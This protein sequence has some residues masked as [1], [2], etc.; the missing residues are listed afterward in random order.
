[1]AWFIASLAVVVLGLAAVV[2]AGGFGQLGPVSSD[3]LAVNLPPGPL[4]AQDLDN[5]RL[6]VVPRGYAMDQV[7][8]VLSRLRQQL[9]DIPDDE[10]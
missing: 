9:D 3:R 5:L 10:G 1:M 2:G 8:E 7:D 6:T 4:T